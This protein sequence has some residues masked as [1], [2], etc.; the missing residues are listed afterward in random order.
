MDGTWQ[1]TCPK[2]GKVLDGTTFDYGTKSVCSECAEDQTD[3]LHCECGSKVR[4]VDLDAGMK[5]DSEQAKR[6]LT[7]GQIYEVEALSVGSW[8]S[9]IWLKEFPGQKFNTV[10]F[11]R[12]E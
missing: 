12:C 1:N 7:T 2:C 3:V 9:S 5:S 11:V 10:H 8:Y 6:L 4:A